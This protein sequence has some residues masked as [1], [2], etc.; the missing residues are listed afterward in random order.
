MPSM[1]GGMLEIKS[2]KELKGSDSK[3]LKIID[4][5]PTKRHI[6]GNKPGHKVSVS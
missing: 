3:F 2:V 5:I 1:R 4:T 6:E